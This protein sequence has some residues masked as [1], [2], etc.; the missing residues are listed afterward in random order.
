MT[1]SRTFVV[2]I[3]AAGCSDDVPTLEVTATVLAN[4]QLA[5]PDDHIPS[6]LGHYRWELVEA[7]PGASPPLPREQTATITIM[8]LSRGLYA[9]DR[10]FV[11]DAAEQ[12]SYHVVVTVGGVAPTAL[13]AGPSMVAIGEPATF[14][15]GMSTSTEHRSLTF[16]WRLTLRPASSTLTVTD[17]SDPTLVLV[18]DVAGD[19]G[20]ELRVFDGE[21]WSQPATTTLT[22]R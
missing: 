6:D 10:W 9:Y 14:N 22:A 15:G 19:Y 18:P 21:L 12:L 1:S 8:P 17:A 20:I 7:P 11:D 5:P 3:V 2:A 16:Q 4:V 13:L